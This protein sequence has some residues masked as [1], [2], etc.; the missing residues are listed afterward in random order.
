MEYL[1]FPL[2]F[3]MYVCA[4][5][6]NQQTEEREKKEKRTEKMKSDPLKAREYIHGCLTMKNDERN[7]TELRT[8]IEKR[9]KTDGY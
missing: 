8:Y 6:R 7:T 5:Q 3:F 9:E 1:Y 4:L 2:A